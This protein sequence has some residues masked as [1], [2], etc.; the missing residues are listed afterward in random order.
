MRKILILL[1][2]ILCISSCKDLKQAQ[3]DISDMQQD[4]TEIFG[5]L[6]SIE[7][8]LAA[9]QEA[10]DNGKIIKDV[11]PFK[12]SEYSGWEIVFSDDS[13]IHIY[14]GEDAVI[15]VL[16]I[17]QQLYWE[18]SYDNGE[19]FELVLDAEGQPIMSKG[20][21]GDEALSLRVVINDDGYYVIES[22]YESN[23]DKVEDSIEL[24]VSSSLDSVISTIVK[25]PVSEVITLIMANGD[26]YKFNLDVLYPTGIVVL[27]E[28]IMMPKEGT[29]SF[30]FRVNPS[31][32]VVKLDLDVENP[33][34]ELDMVNSQMTR[35]YVTS[36][37]NYVLDEIVCVTD[38][39]G[40]LKEGQYKAVVR[41]LG[42][43]DEYAEGAVLVLNTKD[44]EGSS[45]QISSDMFKILSVDKPVFTSFSI[46]G[47][48]AENLEGEFI[49]IRL[50]YGTDVTSLSVDFTIS[51]GV[52]SV[53]DKIVNPKD[54]IDFSSPVKFTVTDNCGCSCVYFVSVSYS[55]IP[56]VYINTKDSAPIVSKET[57]LKNTDIYITNAGEHSKQYTSA[58]IRGRG[59]TTWGYTK[60]PYAIKL[61]S[62]EEVLGMPKHK[63]WVLL[64]NYLDKTCIRNSIAFEISKRSSAIAWTPKGYH[65]DVV[66]NG[67]FL[68]NYFLCE[69]VKIDENRVD[70]TEMEASDNDAESITGGYLLE[71]DNNMDEIFCFYTPTKFDY[72]PKGLP[73]MVKEPEDPTTEQRTWLTNHIAEVE[74]A[75]YSE[76][77][78]T[79]DYLKYIDLDSFIDY[80]LV[81][82]LT[83]T[84]EPTHPKS[85]YMWKERGGKIHAGPVWDFD[86]FT[87][88]PAYKNMLIN[89]NAV[90]NNRIINDPS[91]R[92]AIKAR[93]MASRDKYQAILAE[94]DRQYALVK[95]SAEYDAQLWP[96]DPL[97]YIPNINQDPNREKDL[98]V[99]QSVE[100]MRT[101]YQTKFEYMDSYFST[102]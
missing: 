28:K 89:T 41:D 85:V 92:A 48:Y 53:D 44:A 56:V 60:K 97:F 55:D 7:K 27:A 12:T 59:N 74:S 46:N 2:S 33:M 10:Y 30:I 6:D 15:P 38:E 52:V 1:F 37:A 76:G 87:F 5:K 51:E 73:L 99:Q 69:Q 31:N 101:Y 11:K 18:V 63:R 75:L 102:F 17:N 25:D 4:I 23:P 34:F 3:S 26:E 71:F 80:W 61:D 29:S 35:S 8:Q 86:Y 62:K 16:K 22:Y 54:K 9:L 66:L 83:G 21:K 57:W 14:D 98:T 40:K 82:E 78:T 58:Q 95:E 70:I 43:S 24:P 19:T 79:E 93:W 49:T 45:I 94:I 96:V 68:G 13:S 65:V 84:G 50:P 90:W 81:Y 20:D 47:S 91:N 88:H 36:S 100:R 67:E 32:A 64:A 42:V 39:S 72:R 77:S